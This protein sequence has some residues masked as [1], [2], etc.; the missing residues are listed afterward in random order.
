MRFRDRTDAGKR[1]AGEL[2]PLELIDPIVLALPRGGVPVAAEIARRIAAPLDLIQVCKL[3]VPGEPELAAGALVDSDPPD[4][5]FNAEVVR[6]LGLTEAQL[7]RMVSDAS[8]ELERRRRFFGRVQPVA[9]TGK[10]AILVDDGV[11]TGASMKAAIRALRRRLPLAIIVAIPVAPRRVATELA[12]A[13][14]RLVCLE[15]PV[16]F[17]AVG[18]HYGD[19]TQLVDE[20][21]VVILRRF[22]ASPPAGSAG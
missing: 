6:A 15:R 5:V 17:V 1:L 4:A 22:E 3:G 19:F 10:T 11:A 8:A 16:S 13:A 2:V 14:D 21:V 7:T 12:A 20:D 18:A 9:V